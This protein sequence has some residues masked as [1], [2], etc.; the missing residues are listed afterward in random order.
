MLMTVAVC[1]DVKI[2]GYW[3]ATIFWREVQH[4]LTM[5]TKRFIS[6]EIELLGH[7]HHH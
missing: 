7:T 2:L 1:N 3:N 5:P 6:K 4:S